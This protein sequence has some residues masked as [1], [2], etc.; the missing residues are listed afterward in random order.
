MDAAAIASIQ[1]AFQASIIESLSFEAIRLRQDAVARASEDTFSW[2]FQTGSTKKTGWPS[3]PAWLEGDVKQ[4][5]WITGK[6]GSGKS[7]LMSF[8]LEHLPF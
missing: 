6:P 3:F 8:V 5:Y 1:A 2:V 4:P 7:T